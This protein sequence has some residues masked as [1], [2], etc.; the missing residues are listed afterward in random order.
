MSENTL[1]DSES[2][3]KYA[4]F[5]FVDNP[6]YLFNILKDHTFFS[7]IKKCFDDEVLIFKVFYCDDKE[8]KKNQFSGI[9]S[10]AA[11]SLVF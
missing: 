5:V 6:E 9:D 11:T 4:G 10:K 3:P 2:Y 1:L 7:N 8:N